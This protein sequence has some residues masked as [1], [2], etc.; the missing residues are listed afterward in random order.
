MEK[1]ELKSKITKL[2]RLY[3]QLC[4]TGLMND[5]GLCATIELVTDENLGTKFS[6]LFEPQLFD[7]VPARPVFWGWDGDR[8]PGDKYVYRQFTPFRATLLAMFIAVLE[9]ELKEMK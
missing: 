7:E 2:K 8:F 1:A 5:C 3:N 6:D 4:K 9:S